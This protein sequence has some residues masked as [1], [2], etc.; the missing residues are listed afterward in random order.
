MNLITQLA[1]TNMNQ[2]RLQGGNSNSRNR[3]K[4][5]TTSRDSRRHSFSVVTSEDN[6]NNSDYSQ[7]A[8]VPGLPNVN[9]LP[10]K[11]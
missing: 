8:T 11:V 10:K 2:D 6:E 3:R 9:Q 7:E 4:P 1:H 5:A